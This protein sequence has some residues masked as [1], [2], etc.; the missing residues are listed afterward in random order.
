MTN[1]NTI[2]RRDFI[3]SAA[4]AG[5]GLAVAPHM[6]ASAQAAQAKEVS[7]STDGNGAPRQIMPGDVSALGSAPE[8]ADSDIKL[9]LDCDVLVIGA[10][11]S[12]LAAARS[13]AE[14]GAKVM[15]MEKNE[16]IEIHGFG[17]GVV[18]SGFATSRGIEVDPVAIMNEYER[19]SYGR[20][21]MPLVALWACH[22]GE[23]FDWYSNVADEF[24]QENMT[25]NFYP[26]FEEHDTSA[27]QFQTFL[28]CIDF[29]EDPHHEFDVS[30]WTR[31]GQL[32]QAKAE[33][34]GAEFLFSTA[35][36]KLLTNSDGVVT[37][38][39][40]LTADGSYTQV[41]ASKG[42]ILCTGGF[43]QVGA[44]SEVMAKVF[45][46]SMYKNYVLLRNAEPT[47]QP[48]FT[49]NP[50]VIQGST[51]D[52]QL[53]AWWVGGMIDPFSDVGMGSCETGI[54]GTVSL[55]VN[56]NG[57]RFFNE[58]IGIW[59]KHDQVLRQPGQICYDIIDVNWRDRLPFQGTGHRNFDYHEHQVA[60]GY[61][62]ITYVNTFHEE[63]LSSVGNPEGVTPSLDRHA[64][65]V[66][67]ANTLEELA[68]I[69]GV[70]RE[71]FLATVERYNQLVDQGRDEDFGCDSQKLFRIDTPPFFA[72]SG[73]AS[74]NFAAY[75]GLIADGQLR[76]LNRDGK[77][78]GGLWTAGN[79]CG[80]KFGPSYFTPIPAMNHGNGITHGYYAGLNAAQSQET[81]G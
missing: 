67:G 26:P 22:S 74:P 17:C 50:G 41:N 70:P 14:A 63:F 71:R 1:Q 33:E 11:I 64:G 34:E 76:V 72:C 49:V 57:E 52:G 40:G 80:G 16:Q 10:G 3:A 25:L 19:R 48:M 59:E 43:C 58:D 66:Y 51:G 78:I 77:P 29:K 79:C 18:N 24:V 38:A 45:T 44:G 55:C 7:S 37:G 35:A 53:M 47:W 13:A 61:D 75:A 56:Q 20:C 28:G 32:N 60:K 73:T 12:G 31:L 27:D 4:A 39:I 30:P 23:V 5:T 8:I 69:I 2:D 21:N 81:A 42:V 15:V 36:Q 46:P 65:T 9:K 6:L 68:D 54:G 62:G